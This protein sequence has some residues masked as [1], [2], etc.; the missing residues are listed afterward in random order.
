M[1]YTT[2]LTGSIILFAMRIIQIYNILI[3]A[4]VFASWI[5]RNPYNRVYHFLITITEPV[6]GLI[7]R[8][9]PPLMGLDLS[10]IIAFFLLDLLS[11]LLA[12]LM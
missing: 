12:S 5:V 6:L 3:I 1:I 2:S 4:R 11:R 7:R 9:L 8:I 10:P